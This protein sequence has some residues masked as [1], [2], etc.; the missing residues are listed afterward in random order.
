MNK[1]TPEQEN[2]LRDAMMDVVKLHLS[3]HLLTDKMLP[4]SN[5]ARYV[6]YKTLSILADSYNARQEYEEN[7]KQYF[8][9]LKMEA[10]AK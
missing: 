7:A 4:C 5:T 9:L 6:C 1:L 2:V 10:E 8:E 3:T